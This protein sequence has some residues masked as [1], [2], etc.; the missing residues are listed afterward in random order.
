MSKIVSRLNAALEGRYR[1]DRE[2]GVGGMATVFLADDVRHNR[3]VA[4]KVLKPELAAMVGGERFLAEIET[5]ANLH[6]PHILPLFDSGEADGFL[7]FVM[8][9]VEGETLRHRLDREK[10]LPVDEAVTIA[11]KVAGALQAAHDR[12]VIHRDI[13]P[14]NILLQNG[15]P[16]VADFGIALAMEQASGGRMTETG[17]SVGT[18]FY[19]S[20]EQ[21][22]ADRDPDARSD[23][24]SL[25]CVL[26]EMLV[27]DPPHTGST[28]Q[29]VVAKI[30]TRDPE[31]VTESRRTVP[32]HVEV[33]LDRALQ[34][35]PADR[36]S[37]AA[38]FAA[39]LEGRGSAAG[40]AAASSRRR[41]TS[42]V[43]SRTGP[44]T[45]ATAAAISIALW[46]WFRPGPALEMGVPTH[47]AVP[48]P[49]L[50]GA[51][52]GQDLQLAITPDGTTLLYTAIAPD[53]ENRTMRRFMHELESAVLPGVVPFLAGYAIS[54]DGGSFV[55]YTPDNRA[56][57]YSIDGSGGRTLPAGLPTGW[58]T[59]DEDGSVWFSNDIPGQ[60]PVRV[61]SSGEVTKP[62]EDEFGD[63]TFQQVLPGGRWA[64]VIRQHQGISTGPVLLL[65]LEDGRAEPLLER[66][67]AGVQYTAGYLL[68]VSPDGVLEAVAFDADARRIIGEP[69][70]LAQ[71]IMVEAGTTQLVTA[72]NGTVAY[73]PEQPR[74]LALVSR[75]GS[76]RSATTEDRNFHA[77]AFSPDGTRL[78]VDFSSAEGRNVWVIDLEDG[79]PIRATF[80]RN[81]HDPRWTPDGEFVTYLAE[82]DSVQGFGIYRTRPG[83]LNSEQLTNQPGLSFAGM[84]LPD[85][86]GIVTSATETQPGLRE[87]IVF[88]PDRG[89]GPME[90]IL[91][92]RYME[93]WPAL[94]P[95]G[96]W[97]AY[98]S[99]RSGRLEVYAAPLDGEG[100]LI[101]VSLAGGIEP[102]WSRDG[103]ELFYRTGASA[104]SEMMTARIRTEP[105]LEVISRETL[106]S[107]ADMAT[108]TPHV[109]Y[110]VS[111]DGQTFA[112]VLFN[113]A[114][115]VMVIQN[116]PELVRRLGGGGSD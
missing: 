61:T 112:M 94:S 111:P 84:W 98:V 48:L 108:A 11:V 67:M 6:H 60:G 12:G 45:A 69:V 29:A 95:D 55:G 75:D 102:L 8:P 105:R 47:L 114:S 59:W 93:S 31:P 68:L 89:T 103:T 88:L 97:L 115:R 86:S 82:P 110:D 70:R 66:D 76:R 40:R 41:A 64:L 63:L 87:D 71:D 3:K 42:P 4:I 18:P 14:A 109:N 106:F 116:L 104:G 80:D 101:Q 72:A 34:R 73:I 27:G 92:T 43:W 78:A 26:Y 85:G 1:I 56:F 36:F 100:D 35:L 39:A 19:M 25:A 7:F 99:D 28:A 79:V 52:T 32:D 74:S 37:R 81:G 13:K 23:L 54:A 57:R 5:T 22:T 17:L 10:Q 21:A 33:A 90:P 2:L 107:V 50:G 65:D 9:Y 91:A 46:G 20:P 16:L 30:L 77:P 38:E 51:A 96:E 44:W 49:T 58:Q 62:F 15:E 24:Y 113:P 53:G 83:S